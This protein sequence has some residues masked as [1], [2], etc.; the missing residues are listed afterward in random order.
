MNLGVILPYVQ[1]CGVIFEG[2]FVTWI[3]DRHELIFT[4]DEN[5]K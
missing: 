3:Q 5:E 2:F 4:L 1:D